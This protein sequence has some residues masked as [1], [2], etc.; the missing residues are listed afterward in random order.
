[1]ADNYTQFSFT[2]K[3]PES[4]R[5]WLKEL[6]DEV[7]ERGGEGEEPD[8]EDRFCKIFPNWESCG[9]V[10]FDFSYG[11]G[12]LSVWADEHGDPD[13][14]AGLLKTVMQRAYSSQQ[15]QFG[16]VEPDKVEMRQ[17]GFTYACTCSRMR[18]NE[19]FGGAVRIFMNGSKAEEEWIDT[20][21][22]LNE[23]LSQ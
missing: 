17:V 20:Y 6:L 15:Q 16:F 22:W 21:S 9:S 5:G 18:D 1:M 3:I 4:Q 12:V 13:N 7:D 19:F 23:H 2:V 14:V 11:D 10:D 8:P